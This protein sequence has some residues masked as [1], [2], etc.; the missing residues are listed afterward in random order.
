MESA[1]HVITV[2]RLAPVPV[3]L[4]VLPVMDLLTK[5]YLLPQVVNVNVWID[6]M[7]MVLNALHVIGHV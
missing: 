6:F 7:M 1:S 3:N 4:P 2:V 5:E